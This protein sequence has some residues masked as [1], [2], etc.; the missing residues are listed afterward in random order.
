MLFH[1]LLEMVRYIDEE[2]IDLR[3]VHGNGN[4]RM[5][6]AGPR[7]QVR[8]DIF[9][10]EAIE[11]GDETVL[12]QDGNEL[13]GRHHRAVGPAPTRQRLDPDDLAGRHATLRL[14][15]KGDLAVFQP[16]QEIR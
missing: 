6:R 8:T 10:D 14:Q 15:I 7:L 4:G 5:A 12:F 3:H 9:P 2:E 11:V 13:V 16:M 1:E